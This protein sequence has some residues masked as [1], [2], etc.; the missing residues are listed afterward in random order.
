MQN[1][2][3][4]FSLGRPVQGVRKETR[5]RDAFVRTTFFSA[6]ARDPDAVSARKNN[7]TTCSVSCSVSAV[8]EPPS[9]VAT[10]SSKTRSKRQSSKRR[11]SR[12]PV[13]FFG[14]ITPKHS[15]SI[16]GNPQTTWISAPRKTHARAIRARTLE[17]TL[18]V[19]SPRERIVSNLLFGCVA[20]LVIP[21]ASYSRVAPPRRRERFR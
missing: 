7:D 12:V 5:K 2:Q 18:H 6:S 13:Y 21:R 10:V 11:Q 19:A 8:E 20:R 3:L 4:S 9:S 15:L 17:R 1:V 16:R 14:N